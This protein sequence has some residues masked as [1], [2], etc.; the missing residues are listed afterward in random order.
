MTTV[1][2]KEGTLAADSQMTSGGTK[3]RVKKLR[4]MTDGSLFAGS[5]SPGLVNQMFR[6]ANAGFPDNKL[7]PN[8]TD[9]SE[10]ECMLVNKA[11][12]AIVLIDEELEPLE[13]DGPFAAI[14]SGS[15]YA[16]MA[17]R[18]GK[19]ALEAVELAAEFDSDTSGPMHTMELEEKK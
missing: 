11:T 12:S 14:G 10:V 4:R 19:T 6:W 1:A 13:I 2:F 7:K 5:G 16:L 8:I 18:L 9:E 15:A 17:M 3:L